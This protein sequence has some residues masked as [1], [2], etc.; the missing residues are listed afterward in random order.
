VRNKHF[1]VLQGSIETLLRWG[2]KR[3]CHFIANLFRKPCVKFHQHRPSFV[4]DITKN[5]LVSFF[6]DT[7]LADRLGIQCKGE[8]VTCAEWV[9]VSEWLWCILF[10]HFLVLATV[11][12]NLNYFWWEHDLLK[13]DCLSGSSDATT[14]WRHCGHCH[15]QMDND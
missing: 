7:L 5:I 6:P 2:G 12:Q 15:F 11:G 9:R 13:K 1:Q 10:I 3:L 14:I 4:W 8:D